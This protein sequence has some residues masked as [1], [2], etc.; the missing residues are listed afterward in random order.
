MR[1][2]LGKVLK[3]E[4]DITQCMRRKSRRRD[5]RD[6]THRRPRSNFFKRTAVLLGFLASACSA[7]PLEKSAEKPKPAKQLRAPTPKL[8]LVGETMV[9][10]SPERDN[11]KV[12]RVSAVSFE[13]VKEP[14]RSPTIQISSVK[15][16]HFTVEYFNPPGTAYNGL[17]TAIPGCEDIVAEK[18]DPYYH[19]S[20]DI[21]VVVRSSTTHIRATF[22]PRPQDAHSSS[23]STYELNIR[24]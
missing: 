6:N 18:S 3:R 8:P 19:A 1:F 5:S 4:I 20:C 22:I 11:D 15:N 9:I 12:L 17:W 13:P 7:K 14:T 23:S 16:A 10:M 24:E 21:S 2:W